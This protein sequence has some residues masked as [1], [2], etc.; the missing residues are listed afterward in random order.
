MTQT[1]IYPPQSVLGS[2]FDPNDLV[3]PYSHG[4]IMIKLQNTSNIV[5]YEFDPYRV[6]SLIIMGRFLNIRSNQK[7]YISIGFNTPSDAATALS[8]I[9]S[10]IDLFKSL[11][12]PASPVI[13]ITYSI[14]YT[15][16]NPLEVVPTIS[17]ILTPH[18]GGSFDPNTF[19]VTY[20]DGD[21]RI[22][23]QDRGN[24]VV[25]DIN[26]NKVVFLTVSGR[27]LNISSESDRNLSIDFNSTSDAEIALNNLSNTIE[28]FRSIVADY[29]LFIISDPSKTWAITHTL[30]KF[31]TVTI[32]SDD[33]Q[34]IDAL[35]VYIDKKSFTVEFNQDVVGK[36]IVN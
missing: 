24:N 9:E 12:S 1:I 4:D 13:G 20:T 27:F 5:I 23:L 21:N 3:V 31:P 30:K 19:V 33:N 29:N 15:P 11:I 2:T 32:L 18:T 35:V 10:M 17:E 26:P 36:V 7:N 28:I 8:N 14:T 34:V 25:F 22:K 16:T 6:S